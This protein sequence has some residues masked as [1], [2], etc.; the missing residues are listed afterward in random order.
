VPGAS[1]A[2]AASGAEVP[3]R[4]RGV[5][6]R[7]LSEADVFAIERPH[8]RLLTGYFLSSLLGGPLF[9]FVFLVRFVRFRTLRYRFDPS[10]ISM[11]WGALFRREI[12]LTY[13][14]IQDI[15]LASNIVERYLGLARI[16]IQTASGTAGAE[17][18]LEGLDDAPGVR[19]YLYSRMRGLR[20]AESFAVTSTPGAGTSAP[21]ERWIAAL[22]GVTQALTEV[23]QVLKRRLPERTEGRHAPGEA[24]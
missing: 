8:A 9:P 17:M 14:R 22:G 7:A 19:N 6:A 20:R 3:G 15:H 16:Q 24:P 5:Q 4:M 13:A 12:H 10:G 11:S 21:E 2:R 1:G 23:R 18:T